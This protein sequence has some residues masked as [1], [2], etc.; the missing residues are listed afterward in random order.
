MHT[1]TH[2]LLC[3][4]ESLPHGHPTG[5]VLGIQR[6]R[7]SN[8]DQLHIP[9]GINRLLTSSMVT[10]SKGAELGHM[11]SSRTKSSRG[12]RCDVQT[13]LL[14]LPSPSPS[15]GGGIPNF[16]SSVHAC[17]EG[18]STSPSYRPDLLHDRAAGPGRPSSCSG[19]R[20]RCVRR[21]LC[22][23]LCHCVLCSEEAP[24]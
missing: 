15:G 17:M 7:F 16:Q 20:V 11:A 1:R 5:A 10:V 21:G 19:E 23:G 18:P 13:C 6:T 22:V 9:C 4:L 24:G 3:Y 14:P 12:P 8:G 2:T